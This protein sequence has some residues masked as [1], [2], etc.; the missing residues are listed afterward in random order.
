MQASLD[1]HSRS[2]KRKK[3]Y[4]YRLKI[5]IMSK[6]ACL[7]HIDIHINNVVITDYDIEIFFMLIP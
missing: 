1:I 7:G 6:V 3:N 2:S 4:K 5:K